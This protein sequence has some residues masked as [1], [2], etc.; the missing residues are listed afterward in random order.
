[1]GKG[2]ALQFKR[3]YPDM[4][5]DY[6]RAVKSGRIGIGKLHYYKARDGKTIINFPTKKHWR[7]PSRL[8]Y[9]EKGLQD[10]VATYKQHGIKSVAFPK[11]GAGLG[12]LA[13]R[14]VKRLMEKYLSGLD[15]RV[16]IYE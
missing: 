9:I 3:R 15:I 11:I 1:M 6:V 12:G 16:E 14:D 8:E 4:F 5:S 13:W 7:N 10:F 2:L